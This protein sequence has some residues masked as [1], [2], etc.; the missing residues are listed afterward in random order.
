MFSVVVGRKTCLHLIE[1]Y[2]SLRAAMQYA[3]INTLP[4]LDLFTNHC[5]LMS[6][7]ICSVGKQPASMWVALTD[8]IWGEW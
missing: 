5:H 4:R 7:P 1:H 8:E 6:A 2:G 3:K